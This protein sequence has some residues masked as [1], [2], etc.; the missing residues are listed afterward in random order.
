MADENGYEPVCARATAASGH[1]VRY[2]TIIV[3]SEDDGVYIVFLPEWE[4]FVYQPV[5]RTAHC[6]TRGFNPSG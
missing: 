3:W 5:T 2:R 1:F 6:K 4:G